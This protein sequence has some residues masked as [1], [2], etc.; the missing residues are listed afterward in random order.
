MLLLAAANLA[1]VLTIV[2]PCILPVLPFVLSRAGQPS[3]VTFC[4]CLSGWLW[5]SLRSAR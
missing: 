2:S 5:L 3:P 4:Q 1:G